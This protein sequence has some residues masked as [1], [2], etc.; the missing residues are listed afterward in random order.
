M[1]NDFSLTSISP[2]RLVAT[3]A[4]ISAI[5]LLAP[6]IAH[7]A[8]AFGEIGQNVAANAKGVAKGVTVA[9]FAG[10]GGFGGESAALVVGQRGGEVHPEPWRV[11][12]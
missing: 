2:G 6:D 9:G 11:S 5:W 4:A 10:G 8:V 7:A 3:F 12:L 1:K